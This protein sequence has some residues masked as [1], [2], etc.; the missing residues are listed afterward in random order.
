MRRKTSLRESV[1]QLVA[2]SGEFKRDTSF[3]CCCSHDPGTSEHSDLRNLMSPVV[4][5]DGI[6]SVSAGKKVAVIVT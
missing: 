2:K 5:E 1:Q 3:I 6:V 4:V